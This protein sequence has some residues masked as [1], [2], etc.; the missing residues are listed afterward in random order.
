MT[1]GKRFSTGAKRRAS[2]KL[3]V[4]IRPVDKQFCRDLSGT[5]AEALSWVEH[6]PCR[7]EL[8]DRVQASTARIMARQWRLGITSGNS[9][10]K[11]YYIRC[12][13]ETMTSDDIARGRLV[14][15]IGAAFGTPPQ[16]HTFQVYMQ[17]R[18]G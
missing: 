18:P 17:S 12:G 2:P 13:S 11:S 7:Q 8:W 1:G 9:P 4:V 15:D 16:F 3:L 10:E 5:I 6:E 14:M